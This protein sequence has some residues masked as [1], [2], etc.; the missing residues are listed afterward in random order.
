[1]LGVVYDKH[2]ISC[3][4][5]HGAQHAVAAFVLD[6]F[7]VQTAVLVVVKHATSSCQLDKHK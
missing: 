6:F 3:E 4:V 2:S 1:M 7:V 5:S